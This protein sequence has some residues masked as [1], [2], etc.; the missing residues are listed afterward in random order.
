M[1]LLLD[2]N[3]GEEVWCGGDSSFCDASI[4]KVVKISYRYDKKTGEKYKRIHL[5]GKRK[6][7]AR[8]GMALNPPLAYY[9]T[10]M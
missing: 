7:D 4:E 1:N 9:I 3:I 2:I 5:K 8:T 10:T 6:F